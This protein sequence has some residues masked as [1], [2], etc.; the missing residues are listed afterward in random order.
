V[1]RHV[2]VVRSTRSSDAAT[3][4]TATSSEATTG[5]RTPQRRF[6]LR[7]KEKHHEPPAPAPSRTRSFPLGW[8]GTSATCDG[9]EPENDVVTLMENDST[10]DGF[11]IIENDST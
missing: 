9:P 7:P 5:A 3:A 8:D 2:W 11:V 1:T 6:G 4:Q 10:H